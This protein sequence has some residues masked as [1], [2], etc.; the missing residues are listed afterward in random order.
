MH[1]RHKEVV[2]YPD[3][4]NKPPLGSGLNCPAIVRLERV[5]PID[6]VTRDPIKYGPQLQKM[7]Y[8]DNLRR[9]CL[10]L[11]ADFISYVPETGVWT[12]KVCL[13]KYLLFKRTI[14]F[15]I[16]FL[17]IASLQINTYIFFYYKPG[18]TL[19]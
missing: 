13:F 4:T 3:D 10:R 16:H 19:F 6:K 7:G 17:F 11:G 8:E 15:D 12:F 14:L 18:A 9:S 5:W 2:V 1:F